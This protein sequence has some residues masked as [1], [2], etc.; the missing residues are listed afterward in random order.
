MSLSVRVCMYVLDVCV[1]ARTPKCVLV[2]ACMFVFVRVCV[3][4]G[5]CM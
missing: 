2:C 5:L 3:C 4:V 1:C